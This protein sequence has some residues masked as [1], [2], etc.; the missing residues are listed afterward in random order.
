M[1]VGSN[2]DRSGDGRPLRVTGL[3]PP[4]S[5]RS[6][7]QPG[8]PQLHRVRHPQHRVWGCDRT[9]EV[10]NSRLPKVRNVRLPLTRAELHRS[11]SRQAGVLG[12]SAEAVLAKAKQAEREPLATSVLASPG[13]AAG[14]AVSWAVDHL[15]ER[16]AVFG[17][18][19]LLAATLAHDP[20]AVRVAA[21]ERAIAALARDG[22]LH[23]AQ[24][25]GHARFWTTGAAMARESETIALMRAGQGAGK[26][27][28]RRWIAETKLHRGRL[29]EGQKE[30][31]RVI[32]SS[33]DRIRRRAPDGGPRLRR[34][35]RRA[36]WRENRGSGPRCCS[37]SLRAT[38][39]SPRAG[40]R[41]TA[42]AAPTR[43]GSRV[44]RAPC[45]PPCRRAFGGG[46]AEQ[47]I[48]KGELPT[49]T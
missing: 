5:W 1:I 24:G 30:A 12:F 4:E 38:R 21:A 16:Q 3:P 41:R 6:L 17:H 33:K 13:H 37:G 27:I 43:E 11:W 44:A 32:L 7:R 36:P 25:L 26:T 23:A 19:G 28:M 49:I 14:E 9:L 2:G 35:R 40:A 29:N 46:I 8:Y 34:P 39:A 10:S 47:E 45:P 20:G 15:S 42:R 31:V 18:A 22:G 48:V